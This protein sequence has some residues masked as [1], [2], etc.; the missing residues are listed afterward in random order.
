MAMSRSFGG[1]VVDDAPAD[2]DLAG[3]DRLEPGDHREQRRLAAAGRADQ[4]DELA[5]LDLE[6]D[7]LQHL[8]G[9]E[10]LAD[11]LLTVSDAMI[12]R[13]LIAPWVRPRTK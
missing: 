4:H 13:Y 12:A 7:V 3:A 8:D 2:P 6:V 11:S 9:A 10:A 1:D 5:G